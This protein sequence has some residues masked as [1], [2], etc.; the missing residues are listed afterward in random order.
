M[1][2][3]SRKRSPIK[4]PASLSEVTFSAKITKPIT[5]GITTGIRLELAVNT[6]RVFQAISAK[7]F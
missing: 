6:T 7:R 2:F 1:F 3:F 5:A 4:I